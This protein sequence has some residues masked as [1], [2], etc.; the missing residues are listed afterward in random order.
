MARYLRSA[1][2]GG[3]D[4]VITSLA[5][6]A[7]SSFLSASTSVVA[8][9]GSSSLIADGMS[10]GVSEY[11]SVRG[12][13]MLR[14]E[15]L[16]PAPNWC[17]VACFASFILCGFL[18]LLMFVAGDAALLGAISISFLVL[19]CLGCV[20]ARVTGEVL[21]W[22]LVETTSLGSLASGIAFAVAAIS[23]GFVES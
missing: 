16:S 23:S 14:K 6:V 7:G 4:G 11:L 5:I 22:S 12:D 10:M 2:L 21:L 20:R 8:V 15:S 18:P 19:L 9:V 3:V 1:L 17:G 13:E